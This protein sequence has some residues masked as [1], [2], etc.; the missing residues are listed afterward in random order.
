MKSFI[1]TLLFAAAMG[2]RLTQDTAAGTTTG[3]DA[4]GTIIA[5]PTGPADDFTMAVR[6][7]GACL[8]S[9]GNN[10]Q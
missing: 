3:G 8:D 10:D 6:S 1:A 7:F 2:I 9:H 5:A 4:A